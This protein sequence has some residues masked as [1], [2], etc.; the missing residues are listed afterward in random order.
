MYDLAQ[1]HPNILKVIVDCFYEY[2]ANDTKAQQILSLLTPTE[3]QDLINKQR[4]HWKTLL[5][6][7]TDQATLIRNAQ[8]VGHIHAILGIPSASIANATGFFERTLFDAIRELTLDPPTKRSLLDQLSAR[9]QQE[10]ET[11]L[12]AIDDH[13]NELDRLISLIIK[14][15]TQHLWIDKIHHRLSII[16][17]IPGVAW[18]MWVSQ[19]QVGEWVTEISLQQDE[20]DLSEL[21]TLYIEPRLNS[22]PSRPSTIHLANINQ[23]AEQNHPLYVTGTR[24]LSMRPIY[25]NEDNLSGWMIIAGEY[26]A[27]FLGRSTK[28]LID[29]LVAQFKLDLI[30]QSK[31]QHT[32]IDKKA[33]QRLKH[34]LFNGG[35]TFFYQPIVN[36]KTG[37]CFKLEAL[38][39][40]VDAENKIIPP[41][42][43]LPYFG[44][45][46]I[47]FLFIEGL[48]Q[49]LKKL[50][51]WDQLGHHFQININLP[52]EVLE[53]LSCVDWVAEALKKHGVSGNRLH[54]ELLETNEPIS[55]ARRDEAIFALNALGVS[56][57]M[58]D[59]GS[60]HSGLIR[61]KDLPFTG[62][63]IDQQLVRDMKGHQA[64][65]SFS[66]IKAMLSM[67]HSM[68]LTS[69]VEGL[70][71]HDEL[72]VMSILGADFG[73]GYGI[74]KPMPAEQILPWLS[75]LTWPIDAQN[76][77]TD[78]GKLT[79]LLLWIE[80]EYEKQ[81]LSHKDENNMI[82]HF[83]LSLQPE[84]ERLY[85]M[86]QMHFSRQ[87]FE[88]GRHAGLELV[89]T[90]MQQL[91]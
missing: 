38:A 75:T 20:H 74:A 17:Q 26:P 27:M 77:Q 51:E 57:N 2:L 48:H 14:P 76:P 45:S 62:I 28:R 54:L 19:N 68:M 31:E 47:K 78:L 52:P 70:E 89:Q 24:S 11:Q 40:L 50:L 81:R 22:A 8:H 10:T 72:E 33:I 58:D 7:N 13:H 55:I 29:I 44:Y 86:M 4:T 43:F 60:G 41:G 90:F 32:S 63:K 35:L 34:Y 37:Q 21:F 42:A 69:V 80:E 49:S 71:T 67:A 85:Q 61:L 82:R 65:K 6:P 91:Q 66:I 79:S 39:R 64:L 56:L 25:D 53:D 30:G 18:T 15:N 36:L 9:I 46:E 87:D 3:Y 12:L 1:Y 5:H 83:A 16:S 73:Q 88:S 84:H 59:L 23:S